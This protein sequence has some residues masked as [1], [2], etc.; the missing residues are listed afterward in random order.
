VGR[1]AREDKTKML[2]T[3]YTLHSMQ[4]GHALE[5]VSKKACLLNPNQIPELIMDGKSDESLCDVVATEYEEYREKVLLEPH[6]QSQSKYTACSSVFRLHST[7]IQPA[8]LKKMMNRFGLTHRKNSHQNCSG[9]C[10][11]LQQSAAHTHIYSRQKR[12]E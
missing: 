4:N 3:Q 5:H 9:H 8:P 10:P 12:K 2:H 11:C 1:R 7:Q 6:L